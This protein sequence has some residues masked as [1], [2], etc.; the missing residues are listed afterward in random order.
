MNTGSLANLFSYMCMRV[1]CYEKKFATR[2]L[3]FVVNQLLLAEQQ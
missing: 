3:H 1:V 2:I